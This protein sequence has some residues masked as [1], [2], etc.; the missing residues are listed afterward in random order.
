MTR[1]RRI[2]DRD[3][4][5]FITVRLGRGITPLSPGERDIVQEYVAA[6]HAAYKFLLFGYVVMPDHLH[7]FTLAYKLECTA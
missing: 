5:F 7:R 6:E 1:L 4:I 2:A 3:R